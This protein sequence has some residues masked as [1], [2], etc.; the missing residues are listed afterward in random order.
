MTTIDRESIKAKIA[1]LMA[2]GNC[3]TA[4]P[5]EA[6]TALRQAAFLMRKHAI[7]QSEIADSTGKPT[8]WDWF[9]M[10]IPAD[11]TRPCISRLA[12]FGSLA[13]GIA[14]FTDTKAAWNRLPAHGF[15]ARFSGDSTDVIYAAYLAKLLRDTIRS[16]SAAFAG[17]RAERET[18]RA[19]MVA[20]LSARMR[21]MRA[22]GI[23]EMRASGG[24]GLAII[25]TKLAARDAEFGEARYSKTRRSAGSA[26]AASAGRSAGDKV[27][28]GRPV[29]HGGSGARAL[30]HGG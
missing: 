16:E 6:E 9:S 19:A 4:N 7:E 28:F 17:T 12:W 8:E 10:N 18:F 15:C 5:N 20:R 24:K 26:F 11:P 14:N 3:E 30:S 29:S 1:K 25:D 27:G 13:V 22:E 21:E 2:L 23:A